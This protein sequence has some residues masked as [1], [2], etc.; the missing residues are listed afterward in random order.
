MSNQDDLDRLLE[1]K[2][3]LDARGLDNPDFARR[4]RE[5]RAWQAKRLATS[6]ADLQT[7]PRYVPALQFFLGDL[8]GPDDF[9]RRDADLKRALTHLKRALPARLLELLSEAIE[10]QVL[11]LELDHEMVAQLPARAVSNSAYAAAYRAVGRPD[12]RKRQ[13][14]LITLIGEDLARIVGQRWVGLALRA[15]HFPAHAAGFGVLQ[16]FLE[17]GL[18]AFRRLGDADDL[19]RIIRERETRLMESL[20]RGDSSSIP[21]DTEEPAAHA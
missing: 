5:L 8:Y 14:E 2:L 4:L 15:A 12:D 9:T 11:S 21:L 10:L 19:L 6:Y 17:R 20:L 1:R 3:T 7:R 16:G 18:Q 13:I